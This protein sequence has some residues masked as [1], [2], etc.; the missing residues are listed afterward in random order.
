M[1]RH[2]F[3]LRSCER[4]RVVRH[5]LAVLIHLLVPTMVKKILLGVLIFFGLLIS[6]L[7][8]GAW[9]VGA[10]NLLFP[11]S[12]HETT[13]PV[14]PQSLQEPALLVFSK[15]NR[16]RHF[17]GIAGG[18]AYFDNVAAANNW[19][20]YHTE[21]SAIFN[22]GD[23]SRF[24]AVIFNN[25]TGDVLSET[26][27]EAF[28]TWMEAGGGWLGIHG[29]GDDSHTEWSWY[30]ENLIGARFIAHTMGPQFQIAMLHVDDTTH[31]ATRELPESWEH[32]EEW[33][34][35]DQSVRNNG[36]NVL[37]TV[38]E[39]TYSPRFIFMGEDRD[40]RM[41]DH[42]M[43]WS[44]CVGNGRA[45]Y[46]ALGHSSEAFESPEYQALLK[47]ALDWILNPSACLTQE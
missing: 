19:G 18:I 32:N 3:R 11:S 31:T 1:R 14:V 36:F 38:D 15:T 25:V 29:A 35:W 47:G 39:S 2:S 8:V 42:P 12:H 43:V 45:L 34:S 4:S 46:S 28:E 37:I 13:A 33:Y 26:Q 41:G 17:D 16:Y 30:M 24:S 5:T 9:R 23:L 22:P 40:L 27:E 44:N 7:L 21:N 20:V 6:V 10:W